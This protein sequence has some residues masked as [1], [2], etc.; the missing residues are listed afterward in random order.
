MQ[1]VNH[2]VRISCERTMCLYALQCVVLC[3]VLQ[4]SSLWRRSATHS[5]T[6]TQ[7][8]IHSQHTIE[9]SSAAVRIHCSSA[10]YNMCT[11]LTSIGAVQALDM[12]LANMQQ[13]TMVTDQLALLL[14]TYIHCCVSV[15][16]VCMWNVIMFKVRT[17]L[18]ILFSNIFKWLQYTSF[19]H[20]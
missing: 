14:C 10:K 2:T 17:Y 11:C 7:D 19:N 1:I 3:T 12:H 20:L 4:C 8:N 6:T 18:F 9:T 16:Y 5:S 15:K 13:H